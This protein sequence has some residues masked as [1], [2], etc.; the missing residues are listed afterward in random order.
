MIKGGETYRIISDHLGSPRMVVD[1]ANS[2]AIVQEITYDTFGRIT[3]DTQPGFQPFGF[4]GGIYDTDTKLTRFGARDYDAEIG[5]W[6]SKDPIQFRG[7][8]TNLYGYILNDPINFIDP[9]GQ[10]PIINVAFTALFA[11]FSG[12]CNLFVDKTFPPTNPPGVNLPPNSEPKVAGNNPTEPD[13]NQPRKKD[14]LPE[15]R[16]KSN[17]PRLKPRD[18]IRPRI[19]TRPPFFSPFFFLTNPC[20]IDPQLCNNTCPSNRTS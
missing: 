11:C 9:D 15:P 5:R 10:N 7:G 6:T 2:N 20:I 4:A 17:P 18:I 12:L 16:K 14:R 19:K 8:D 3:S 13:S 1:I